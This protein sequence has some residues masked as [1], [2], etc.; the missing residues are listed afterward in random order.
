MSPSIPGA[1]RDLKVDKTVFT[2]ARRDGEDAFTAVR[3]Q[4]SKDGAKPSQ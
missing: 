1:R 4:V 3:V 2:A